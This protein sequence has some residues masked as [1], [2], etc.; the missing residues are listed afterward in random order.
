MICI[1]VNMAKKQASNPRAKRDSERPSPRRSDDQE[2]TIAEISEGLSSGRL[3]RP[4][5]LVHQVETLLREAIAAGRFSTGKLP[6]EVELAEQL[7]VSR[8]TVRRA[9]EALADAGL[10]VKYRR[11]G[12]FLQKTEMKL[13]PASESR[14]L[15]YLQ[16]DYQLPQGRHE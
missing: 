15:G 3:E 16:A 14:T 7:G 2:A 10:L 5:N 6:I 12:T 8:E 11:R 9:T 13:S 4:L 1:C